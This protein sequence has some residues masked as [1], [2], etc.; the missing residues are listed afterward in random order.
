MEHRNSIKE[1]MPELTNKEISRLLS[2]RWK[3]LAPEQRQA[4][5]ERENQARAEFEVKKKIFEDG[6]LKE[7][8]ANRGAAAKKEP[9]NASK[10]SRE[11]FENDSSQPLGNGVAAMPAK[12]DREHFEGAAPATNDEKSKKSKLANGHD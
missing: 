10:R 4:Y 1:E 9:D 6:P 12:R 7:F 11:E 2:G 5:Q 8:L 3:A